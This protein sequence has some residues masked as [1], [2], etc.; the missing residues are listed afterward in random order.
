MHACQSSF[1]A[2]RLPIGL[3]LS[4][5]VRA[6]GALGQVNGKVKDGED[7]GQRRHDNSPVQVHGA[8]EDRHTC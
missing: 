6:A 8:V 3:S 1:H 5:R 2:L 7:G 4:S